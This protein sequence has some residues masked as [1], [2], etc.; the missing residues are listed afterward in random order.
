MII[1]YGK[2]KFVLK[3]KKTGEI[4]PFNSEFEAE[5]KREGALSIEIFDDASYS[6]SEY[7]KLPEL[8]IY[9]WIDIDKSDYELHLVEI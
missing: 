5:D 3:N 2:V 7:K 6:L 9:R 1:E 4:K 8:N